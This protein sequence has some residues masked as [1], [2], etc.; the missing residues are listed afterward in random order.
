M[1]TFPELIK[2]LEI[3]NS[4]MCNAACPQ[5]L[6]ELRPGDH[7][8]FNENYLPTSFFKD[9]IPKEVYLNLNKLLFTGTI[10]DPCTAPNFI[11]VIKTVRSIAPDIKIAVA[12]NGGMKSEAFWKDLAK[13]LGSN[14]EVVFAIDG[15]EDTNDIYRMNVSWKKLMKNVKSFINAGG[16]ATWQY[17]IFKHNQHQ[18][19]EAKLIAKEVGFQNFL[20]KPS[21]RF[22]V[23]DILETQRIGKNQIVISAPTEDKYVHSIVLKKEKTKF[24]MQDWL[25]KSENT[26]I[27]CYAKKDKSIFIDSLGQIFPCCFLAA[28]IYSRTAINVPDGWDLLWN[29]YGKEKINLNYVDWDNILDSKFFQSIEESWRLSYQEGRLAICA[30]TCSNSNI[31]FHDPNEFDK[32]KNEKIN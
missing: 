9:R 18:V 20:S 19:D 6:R 5:C 26:C 28:S 1:R 31:R 11:D 16:N 2:V 24:V 13:A 17:I 4:S 29:K 15:L 32:M 8:W 25:E 27:E 14:S 21:H 12:T 22:V 3:E 23:D 30:G 7:S 10:G